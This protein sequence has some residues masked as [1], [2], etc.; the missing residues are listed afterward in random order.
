MKYIL[1]T[2]GAG[3]IGSHSSIR[4][5]EE[6]YKLIV[7]DS[8]INSSS[9]TIDRI[10]KIVSK[11]K[12]GYEKNII[13]YKGDL[14]E[15]KYV[16]KI[17]S[18]VEKLG[19]SI[20]YVIHFAGLKSVSDSN[21]EPLKYWASNVS[22]TINLLTIMKKFNCNNLI[23]S[24]SAS[25]YDST[26][27]IYSENSLV[28]PKNPYGNTKASIEKLLSDIYFSNKKKW[29]IACLRYFNPLGA[30]K[31]GLIGEDP[32]GKPNNIFPILNKVAMGT[33]KKMFIYG[34]DYK[35]PD[36][37]GIR[38]YIHVM[39]LAEGHLKTMEYLQNEDPQFLI[40][41]IGTGEGTS[42]LELI[43]TY[44]KINQVKISFSFA[45]RRRGDLPIT[46]ADNSLMKSL[47]KWSPKIGLEDMCKDGYQWALRNIG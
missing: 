36:G 8:F 14:Q 23:F 19:S 21:N 13:A 34:N 2:G 32:Q 47:L 30:H 25:V 42:V 28:N 44:E 12:K 33:L 39:D 24:S 43:R 35:T 46:I 3:F 27:S 31:S 18:E 9:K 6:G 20:F 22:G 29:R 7:L 11:K 5:L 17:F 45:D 40:L 10:K 1:V 26:Q 37:T 15:I 16:E 41:N 4:L 38:D